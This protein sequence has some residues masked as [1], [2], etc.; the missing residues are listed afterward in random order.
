MSAVLE[1]LRAAV[2][3]KVAYWDRMKELEEALD[4]EDPIDSVNNYL[5]DRVDILA[6]NVDEPGDVDWIDQ[7]TANEVV[8]EV[9]RLNEEK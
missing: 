9:K 5:V 7:A 4:C 8:A 6:V 3:A 2:D 1:A